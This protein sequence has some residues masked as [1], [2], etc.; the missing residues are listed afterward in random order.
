[1][2]PSIP[3]PAGRSHRTPM[4]VSWQFSYAVERE[5]LG[6]LYEMSKERQW[7][8]SDA[9]PWDEP[10]DPSRPILDESTFDLARLPFVQRLS[11]SQREAFRAHVAA[12][13]LSQ[14][15]H[16]EQGALMTAAALTHAVPHHE[17]KLYS[18]TQTMDEARHVEAFARYITKLAVVYPM[19]PKLQA[20]IDLTLGADHWVKIAI[21]MNLVVE[22]LALAA[23]HNTRRAT[24]CTVLRAVLDGVLRDE[25]RHVAFGH[26]YVGE[27][28]ADLHPDDREDV[29]DFAFAAMSLVRQARRS[30]DGTEDPDPGFLAVLDAVGIDPPDFARGVAE[31]RAHGIAVEPP[32]DQVHAI[33]DL[34][35]PALVRVGV[36][37]ARTRARYEELG[38]TVHDDPRVLD[39]FSE[40][41]Q[42][43][44]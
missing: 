22:G 17:G 28:V 27:T 1:M 26:L 18:A 39:S 3:T 15:L 32:R 42:A 29:A 12:H 5:K 23:F 30:A 2:T 9:I 7:N 25:A 33:R 8:A 6:R 21:G 43:P 14:F 20:V 16:G 24:A 44:S 34:M 19:S 4:E 36:V 11:R 31:A 10:V 13:Q 41:L 35:L 40:R 37:T 38:I